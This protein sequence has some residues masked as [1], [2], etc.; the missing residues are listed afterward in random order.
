MTL[1]GTWID[2]E[3]AGRD[4]AAKVRP[5]CRE[6]WKAGKRLA[7]QVMELED[8]KSVQQRRFYH[9]V[10]LLEIAEQARVNGQQ[11]NLKVWKEHFRETFLGSKWTVTV[12]PMTGKKKRRKERI[13]TEDL[14]VKAY[15]E[16]I[17]KVSAFAATDLGVMFSAHDW[18][19]HQ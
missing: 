3:Q 17:D 10:I 13:S 14:G 6:Q 16:L 7:Y 1:Q 8:A 9:G 18:R 19:T 15:S 11:F 12:D 4:F 2:P 5:W